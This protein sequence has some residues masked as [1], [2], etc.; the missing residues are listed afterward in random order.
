MLVLEEAAYCDEGFFYETVAPI[1]SIG[2]ASLVAISTLTSE[3]N[4]YTRLIK[5]VDP[6]TERPLFTVRCIELC[7][8]KCKEDGKAH[9]CV[10]M[11]HLVPRW[12]SEERHRKLKIMVCFVVLNFINIAKVCWRLHSLLMVCTHAP[13]A[14]PPR[15]DSI[16]TCRTGF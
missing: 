12:Q 5:M 1:L 4:F 16:R 11:L 7:C 2:S 3:I 8:E 6:S 13:D 14:R 9:E 15:L 10:H